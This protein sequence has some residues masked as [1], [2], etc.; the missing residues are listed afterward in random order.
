MSSAGPSSAASIN[1]FGSNLTA[2]EPAHSIIA[3]AINGCAGSSA[4]SARKDEML[5]GYAGYGPPMCRVKQDFDVRLVK[6]S[7]PNPR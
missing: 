6:E 4:D 7:I 3:S 2:E 1:G 5:N